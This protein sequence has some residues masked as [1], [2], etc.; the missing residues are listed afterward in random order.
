MSSLINQNVPS[1]HTPCTRCTR[2][3][4]KTRQKQTNDR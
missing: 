1:Y 3:D 2:G 4:S